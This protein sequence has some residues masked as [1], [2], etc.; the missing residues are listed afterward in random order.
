[1]LFS[2]KPLQNIDEWVRFVKYTQA[3]VIANPEEYLGPVLPE[4]DVIRNVVEMI[5]DEFLA[6]EGVRAALQQP[7]NGISL[8]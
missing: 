2:R 5:F 8:K 1:M 6:Q 3:S 4:K 7:G